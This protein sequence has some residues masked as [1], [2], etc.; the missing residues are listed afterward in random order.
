MAVQAV[1][2]TKHYLNPWTLRRARGLESLS[3]SIHRGE[4]LGLLGPNGA[5]KTTTMKIL[6]GLLRPSAG[7]AWILG[8]PVDRTASRRRLGFLPEQ[9]YFYDYLT[10]LEYLELAGQ[11]SGLGGHE[12][13]RRARRWLG[14]VGLGDRPRL[15]L[16]KYSK[17]MLQRLG[18]GAALVHEPEVLILDE[19]MSGLDPFGR[20]DVRELIREQHER[21]TTVLFSSHILPDVE[22][23]C[24]RVAIMLEGR[25]ASLA[26]VGQ[27]VHDTRHRVEI[28]CTGVSMVVLPGEWRELV[29]RWD[30]AQETVFE[31]A[32][33]E[34]LSPVLEWLLRTGV[35]VRAVTPQRAG[36]EE[37]FIAAAGAGDGPGRDRRSA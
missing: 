23:L 4:V 28:R 11:L 3:L 2:L 37:L 17:G 34:L 10:G 24:D 20:R 13:S 18:L 7:R 12:A 31:L 9:P 8:E 6:T 33:E 26:P 27:L 15:G 36:L 30:T 29:R 19:P 35:R 16:R 21:G 1:G 32:S 22:M 25:L 14:R 5:G